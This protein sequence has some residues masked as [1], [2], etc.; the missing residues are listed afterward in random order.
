MT[1]ILFSGSNNR[2][3]LRSG[4]DRGQM[5]L[6]NNALTAEWLLGGNQTLLVGLDRF[7]ELLTDASLEELTTGEDTEQSGS[8]R[9]G[10]I[11]HEATNHI[12]TV[13]SRDGVTRHLRRVVLTLAGIAELRAI[14]FDRLHAGDISSFEIDAAEDATAA[15]VIAW[16]E[17]F[18]ENAQQ[19]NLLDI[20][21]GLFSGGIS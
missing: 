13:V 6:I 12:V 21:Q 10:H 14:L 7:T 18:A 17:S 9:R 2:F 1:D 4:S 20:S 3:R 11:R 16:A 8:F 5:W 15:Q 19:S